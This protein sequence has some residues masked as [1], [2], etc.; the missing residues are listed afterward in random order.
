MKNG[1]RS[2]GRPRAL[3]YFIFGEDPNPVI[4][5]ANRLRA[6]SKIDGPRG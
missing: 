6:L 4:I 1:G 5:S 2:E 3:D